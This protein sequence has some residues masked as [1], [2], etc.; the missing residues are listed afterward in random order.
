MLVVSLAALVGSFLMTP[1]YRATAT[2]HIERKNPNILNFRDLGQTDYSWS[3]YEDFYQTQYKILS[4]PAVARGAARRLDL[5]SHPDFSPSTSSPG[6]LSRLKGLIPRRQSPVEIDPLELAAGR[7]LAGLEVTPVRNSQ[8]VGVSW[9]APS[10]ELAAQVA[11]AVTAAY[12]N[13]NIESAYS[14]TDQAGEFLV[15][16]IGNLKLEIAAIEE[17]LQEYGEAKRI[18]SIDDSNNITLRALQDT[19]A[20][21]TTAQNRL[22]Q[23]EAA[24]NGVLE[25]TPD[26]LPEVMNSNLIARLRQESRGLRGRAV[27][28]SRG[29]SG[30]AGRACRRCSPSC[31][32]PGSASTSRSSASRSRCAPRPRRIA[33][34]RGPS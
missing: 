5:P 14:T 24:Y 28:E 21:L 22:A 34:R 2:L 6:L 31:S 19:S 33:T 15:D 16:Q 10:P 17:R 18:V 11:N 29:A 12:V 8:L 26:A 23:A 13:F 20:R 9:V 27:G 3:A 30:T 25:T 4:S 1:L 32:S 7:V